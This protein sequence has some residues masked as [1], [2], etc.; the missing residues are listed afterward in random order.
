MHSFRD[1]RLRDH[2][3]PMSTAWL[4]NDIAEYKGKQ[5]RLEASAVW[6]YEDFLPIAGALDR[7]MVEQGWARIPTTQAGR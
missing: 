7:L 5:E 6:T 3:L 4:L 1:N 2:R